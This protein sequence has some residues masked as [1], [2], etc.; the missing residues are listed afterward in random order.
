ME[1]R[2]K[3]YKRGGEKRGRDVRVEKKEEGGRKE[4]G[5]GEVEGRGGEGKKGGGRNKKGRGGK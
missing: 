1:S 3:K 2:G 5:R 4:E